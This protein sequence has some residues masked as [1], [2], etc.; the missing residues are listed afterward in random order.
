MKKFFKGRNSSIIIFLI[1]IV[2]LSGV[3]IY[4]N[5]EHGSNKPK[6]SDIKLNF[7]PVTEAPIVT[8]EQSTN[9]TET[10]DSTQKVDVTTEAITSTEISTESSQTTNNSVKTG[11][12][13]FWTNWEKSNFEDM[14]V[15]KPDADNRFADML[16]NLI[17][18]YIIGCP[19][20]TREFEDTYAKGFLPNV[21]SVAISNIDSLYNNA[22][23]LV[24]FDDDTTKTYTVSWTITSDRLIDTLSVIEKQ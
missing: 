9:A 16:G 17:S 7:E 19:A 18:G 10:S 12:I 6:K 22:D 5:I 21:K 20:T 11:S 15:Y 23:A 13:D 24:T 8:E 2:L 14:Y 1:M 3:V 4:S